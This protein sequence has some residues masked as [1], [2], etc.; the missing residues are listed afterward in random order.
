MSNFNRDELKNKTLAEFRPAKPAPQQPEEYYDDDDEATFFDK[1]KLIVPIIIVAIVC[2][3]AYAWHTDKFAISTSKSD[4]PIIAANKDPLREKP[5]DPGGMKIINR[6]KRVYDAISGKDTDK[7]ARPTNILP[8][9]E[10]PI[11]HEEIAKK[12]AS[13]ELI[14]KIPEQNKSD[15]K[16]PDTIANAPITS[17]SENQ[18]VDTKKTTDTSATT[19]AA[20]SVPSIKTEPLTSPITEDK[21]KNTTPIPAPLTKTK[22]VTADDITDITPKKQAPQKKKISKND[23]SYRIQ[24]GSYRSTGDAE[25]SWKIMKKKFPD[26][27][28]N[29]NDY[30]EKADLGDKGIFYRLQL[31]GFKNESD[32]RKICQKLTNQK[33][34]CFFVGK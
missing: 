33:Q 24:L 25:A 15:E 20:A 12:E 19:T 18:E 8:A 11:S 3:V 1:I 27:L 34:G 10:E 31:S 28:A 2:F 6:D 17:H 30:I 32:A 5:E 13:P 29:L 9:P 21:V 16:T 26:L 22:A 7:D 23:S 4:L 14:N